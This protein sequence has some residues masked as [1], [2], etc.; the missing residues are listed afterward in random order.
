MPQV[1][2]IILSA[3]LNTDQMGRFHIAIII[4]KN[5]KH[6]SIYERSKQFILSASELIANYSGHF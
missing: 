6:N 2:L 4:S 1:F 3:M 5:S